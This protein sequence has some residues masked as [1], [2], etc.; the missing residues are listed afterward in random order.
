MAITLAFD[1]YGTLIN[2]RKIS[3]LVRVFVGDKASC[4]VD[5]WRTKQLEYSFR[6]A[7]MSDF[8]D[9]AECTRNALDF[10]CASLKCNLN[11]EERNRL[12]REYRVLPIFD[13][14][15]EC[16]ESLKAM[17]QTRLF[18]F[19][20]GG[21]SDVASLLGHAGVLDFFEGIVSVEDVKTFKPN[22]VV[23]NHFLQKS[24]SSKTDTWLISGNS[25]DVIGAVS[26]GINSAWV[27]RNPEDVFDTWDIQPTRTISS[28]QELISALNI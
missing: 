20:N 17:N 2:T 3:D 6:R 21:V 26:A 9:F 22:P 13:D 25:F 12:M 19:S 28:L 14:V 4:F 10:T 11:P 16:L 7:L 15:Y 27:R 1:V 8:T 24:K 18:A 5:V 23:Y